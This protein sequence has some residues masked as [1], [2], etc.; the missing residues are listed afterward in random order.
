MRLRWDWDW[1]ESFAELVNIFYFYNILIKSCVGFLI[2][3]L[4]I[5]SIVKKV[6][7]LFIVQI[8]KIILTWKWN[9]DLKYFPWLDG[10]PVGYVQ[11]S[12]QWSVQCTVPCWLLTLHSTE[13]NQTSAVAS[14]LSQL[15]CGTTILLDISE[16]R[17]EKKSSTPW[18]MEQRWVQSILSIFWWKI[19]PQNCFLVLPCLCPEQ[20]VNNPI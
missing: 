6:H 20:N 14:N 1:A 10:R 18:T 13:R 11:L 5:I 16:N 4:E 12:V 19:V 8:F 15:C 2:K 3:T 9:I 7:R 17:I